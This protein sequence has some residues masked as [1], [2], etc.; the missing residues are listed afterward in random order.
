MVM[1]G[2]VSAGSIVSAA[3]VLMIASFL[4]TFVGGLKSVLWNDLIQFVIYLGAAIAVLIFLW[5]SIPASTGEIIRGLASTPE[6]INKLRLFDLSLD[7][8]RPFSLLAIVTGVFL[9]YVGNSGLDQD[10]T[11]RLLPLPFGIR[12][13]ARG[14]GV[15][16]DRTSALYLLQPT[17]PHGRNGCAGGEPVRGPEHQYL[18]ALHPDRGASGTARAGDGGCDSGS[19]GYD[20]LGA[21]R[22][23]FGGRA[24]LLPSLA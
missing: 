23:V 13:G 2:G 11:Q 22:D 19:G 16:H 8:S 10:T 14:R 1:T 18:H 24:G 21:E 9:L 5:T 4:F 20:E 17:R 6:G 15:R 7:P 12:N 3:A